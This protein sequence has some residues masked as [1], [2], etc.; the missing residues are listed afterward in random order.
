MNTTLS[1]EKLTK[2]VGDNT[3]DEL[4]VRQSNIS[5]MYDETIEVLISVVSS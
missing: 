3:F 4:E 1:Y 2:K 5:E